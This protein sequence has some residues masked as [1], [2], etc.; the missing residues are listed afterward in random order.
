[1]KKERKA[2]FTVEVPVRFTFTAKAKIDCDKLIKMA[3]R[4][5]MLR[6]KGIDV[7]YDSNKVDIVNKQVEYTREDKAKEDLFWAQMFGEKI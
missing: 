5:A 6:L 2:T 4:Q 3:E 1:M 7:R